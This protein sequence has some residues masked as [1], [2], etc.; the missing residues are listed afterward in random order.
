MERASR[1]RSAVVAGLV[2]MLAAATARGQ[3]TS[4][5]SMTG[6][7]AAPSPSLSLYF[8]V[9]AA[10]SLDMRTLGNGGGTNAAGQY[11]ATGGIDSVLNLYTGAGS[12]LTEND[13]YNLPARDSRILWPG[14]SGSYRLDMRPYSDSSLY[15]GKWA[16]DVVNSAGPL[17]PMSLLTN[18]TVAIDTLVLSS[19]IADGATIEL[20][21]GA[22]SV[23]EDLTIRS[24]GRFNLSGGTLQPG[25]IWV[26][27][28][29]FDCTSGTLAWVDDYPIDVYEGGQFSFDND[30]SLPAGGFLRVYI[31]GV[32]S[33]GGN[34]TLA[35]PAGEG[36]YLQVN[37][38]GQLNAPDHGLFIGGLGTGFVT[39]GSGGVLNAGSISLGCISGSGSGQMTVT[40][41]DSHVSVTGSC[42]L[43]TSS[44][45]SASLSVLDAG[46]FEADDLSVG[47]ALGSTGEAIVDGPSSLLKVTDRLSVAGSGT[48]VLNVTGGARVEAA[49]V[50]VPAFSC[51]HGTLSLS[52]TGSTLAAA[53]MTIV[54]HAG[55][56]T[57][58]TVHVGAAT[59]LSVTGPLTVN[60][61]GLIDIAGGTVH[62]GN[63]DLAGG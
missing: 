1:G 42:I 43:G 55:C 49:A 40:G 52:G 31:G 26:A 2:T 8:G 58:G 33:L 35:P 51:G 25:R 19:D 32:A 6:S 50:Y 63:L 36:N 21:G 60:G 15:N 61:A 34:L 12:L 44:G 48:A 41:R 16:L 45:T 20:S 56:D 59:T 11:V 9:P 7:M 29:R 14:A 17:A 22:L 28:G 37:S 3:N 4:Y 57:S 30:L 24:G 53:E 47:A 39:V 10:S 46:R 23:Y 5:I 62:A 27:G 18:G 13:D 54:R 38:G